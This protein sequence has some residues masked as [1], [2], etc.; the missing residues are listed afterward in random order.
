L[1]ANTLLKP[2]IVAC[3]GHGSH[4]VDGGHEDGKVDDGPA[5]HMQV[6]LVNVPMEVSQPEMHM[7]SHAKGVDRLGDIQP[8]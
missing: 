5:G 4:S 1:H 6:Q 8:P 2:R 3:Q 7:A